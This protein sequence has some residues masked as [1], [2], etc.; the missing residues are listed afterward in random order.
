MKQGLLSFSA[1]V[2]MLGTA[3]LSAQQVV[4]NG[5]SPTPTNLGDNMSYNRLANSFTIGSTSS[6]DAVRFW[7]LSRSGGLTGMIDWTIFT[8][9]VGTPGVALGSGSASPTQT[10]NNPSNTGTL[11]YTSYQYDFTVGADVP[12]TGGNYWLALHDGSSAT[13]ASNRDFFWQTTN[14]GSARPYSMFVFQ[15]PT[16]ASHTWNHCNSFCNNDA[17]ELFAPNVTT[18]PEPASIA[19]IGT[20][21]VA[22]APVVRRKKR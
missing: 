6:V 5:G 15:D 9:N 8:D 21:L 3:T 13:D 11:G 17:F 4:F 19:M 20:G 10:P 16:D 14:S 7:G 22:L 12:L 1:V 2:L 18:T